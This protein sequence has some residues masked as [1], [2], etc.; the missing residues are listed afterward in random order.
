M[1]LFGGVAVFTA[2]AEF[3][4]MDVT[5]SAGPKKF[6]AHPAAVTGSTLVDWV[7]FGTENM[8]VDEPLT[9]ILGST[10]MTST[11]TGV[12]G[13]AMPFPAVIH[14][15]PGVFAGPFFQVARKG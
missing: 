3:F 2:H 1:H 6:V 12:A 7:G 9:G 8:T 5:L 15:L 14:L 11:T 10:D 13:G 4:N